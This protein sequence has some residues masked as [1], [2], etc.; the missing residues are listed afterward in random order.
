VRRR[1]CEEMWRFFQET[2]LRPQALAESPIR[3]GEGN[4]E[5]LLHLQLGG[6]AKPFPAD[7]S[8]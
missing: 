6:E 8:F 5:Y 7:F 3:G 2:E 4:L 1:V